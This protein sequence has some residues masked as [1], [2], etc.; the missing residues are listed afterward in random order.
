MKKGVNFLK[1]RLLLFLENEMGSYT[2][3]NDVGIDMDE[4]YQIQV[5]AGIEI[6]GQDDFSLQVEHE[7]KNVCE[8]I[9]AYQIRQFSQL[10][11]IR[12]EDVLSVYE[13]GQALIYCTV[14]SHQYWF[15]RVL[16]DGVKI[17][18][19]EMKPVFK[20][21]TPQGPEDFLKL[22]LQQFFLR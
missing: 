11:E 19:D 20:L 7:C 12:P 6:P 18:G 16:P 2:N 17:E 10:D 3:S 1:G 21:T 15:T 5:Y 14:Y 9:E 22:A 8:F 4:V 13:K